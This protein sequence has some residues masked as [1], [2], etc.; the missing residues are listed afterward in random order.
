MFSHPL[1][2]PFGPA[3]IQKK[4]VV[5][6]RPSFANDIP[7]DVAKKCDLFDGEHIPGV[8]LGDLVKLLLIMLHKNPSFRGKE[9]RPA[10][11]ATTSLPQW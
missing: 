9:N 10:R 8:V 7:R 1:Q 3:F 2:E 4:W 5:C 6:R 11:T